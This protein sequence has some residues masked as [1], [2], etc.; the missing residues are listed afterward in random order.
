MFLAF[1]NGFAALG[2]D[3]IPEPERNRTRPELHGYLK[4]FPMLVLAAD[5]RSVQQSDNI[6]HN[7]FNFRWAINQNWEVQAAQRTRVFWGQTATIPF[8]RDFLETDLN[9]PVDLSHVIFN[10]GNVLLHTITDRAFV[11]YSSGKWQ[12][13]AGRQR[14]NWGINLVSNP[15]DLFNNYSF[16]DFDYEERPGVDALR[17]NWYQSSLSRWELAIA[18]G[19]D[20]MVPNSPIKL[21]NSVAAVL[22]AFNRKGYDIQLVSGYFHNRYALGTGWAGSI[23]GWGFK[24]ELSWFYDLESQ[25]GLERGNVVVAVS[26]DY[27]FANNL[28]WINEVVYNQQRGAGM[29]PILLIRPLRA[30]NLSFSDWS[31]LSTLQYP[32]GMRHSLSL[33]GFYYPTESTL[34]ISPNYSY[35]VAQNLD[36]TVLSQLF[37]APASSLFA[38]AGSTVALLLKW[39]F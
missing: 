7:R 19:R 39:S 24:G 31:V 35:S 25:P 22:Y 21:Q 20:L 17:I 2:Q 12:V 1:L 23:K 9:G 33:A 16:F 27:R 15:N 10:S 26:A 18:P 5:G 29:A 14:I 38:N 6:L 36:L 37:I 34:F 28:F 13:R 3:S 4:N 30:D 8:F 32:I 11:N